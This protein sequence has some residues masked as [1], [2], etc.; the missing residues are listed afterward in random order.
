MGPAKQVKTFSPIT[1]PSGF[2]LIEAMLSIALLALVA[3]GISAP[4]ISGF[5]SLDV[6]ADRMLLDSQL[7]SRMEVLV[8]TDFDSLSAGSEVVTVRGQT[9]TL[10][11]TVANVD[12]DGDLTPEPTARQIIVAIAELPER[13]LVT[14]VVDHEGRVG[15]IS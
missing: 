1:S 10:T 5:Q 11:W 12:L 14:I 4:Y 3:V 13:S 15:K 2:T 6:Q 8:S 7:R 9:Y